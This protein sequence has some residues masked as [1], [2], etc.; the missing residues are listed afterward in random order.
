[1]WADERQFVHVIMAYHS[2]S[3]WVREKR[4]HSDFVK[5][6]VAAAEYGN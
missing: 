1:M 5:P 6:A 2:V 4:V 3:P